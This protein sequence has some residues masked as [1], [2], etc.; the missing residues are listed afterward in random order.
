M[1]NS[2]ARLNMAMC[3]ILLILLFGK[4]ETS[5]RVS[6]GEKSGKSYRRTFSA[7]CFVTNFVVVN[8]V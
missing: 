4:I 6:V 7:L 1:L 5:N 2:I 3:L 8:V